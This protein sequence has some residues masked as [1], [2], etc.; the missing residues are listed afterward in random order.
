MVC[1][2][3]FPIPRTSEPLGVDFSGARIPTVFEG[4]GDDNFR[5]GILGCPYYTYGCISRL[6]TAPSLT[7]ILLLADDHPI[8]SLDFS[9]LLIA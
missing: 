7:I 8:Y 5:A 6:G 3:P 2:F 9:D 1:P 4:S